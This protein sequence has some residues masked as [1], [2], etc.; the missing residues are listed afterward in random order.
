MN[1]SPAF[2][3][4]IVLAVSWAETLDQS[5]DSLL[6]LGTSKSPSELEIPTAKE[7]AVLPLNVRVSINNGIM[8]D[9]KTMQRLG[10]T[11]FKA[12]NKHNVTIDLPLEFKYLKVLFPN[13]DIKFPLDIVITKTMEIAV[14]NNSF[15][16]GLRIE[17]VNKDCRVS[18]S[19]LKILSMNDYETNVIYNMIL[20]SQA[21]QTFMHTYLNT[22]I[23]ELIETQLRD[24][25]VPSYHDQFCALLDCQTIRDLRLPE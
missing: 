6:S 8:S 7:E 10:P 15:V 17:R 4:S 16:V 19:E 25:F 24:H 21:V 9:F 20:N 5:I 3:L 14:R 1:L 13:V 11:K 12:L 23:R 2:T 22:D 18:L